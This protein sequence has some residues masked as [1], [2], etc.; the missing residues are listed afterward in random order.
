M[1]RKISKGRLIFNIFNYVFFAF[2]CFV[3]V[4]PLWH[5][6]C[7]SFSDAS[8]VMA[9]TG[10]VWRIHKFNLS[11]YRLVFEN[12]DIWSGYLNT[13]IYVAVTTVLGML[14]TVM[15]AYTCAK[16]DA[17]FSNF[18]MFLASFTMLFNGGMIA[19]YIVNT[20]ILN[21]YDSRLAIIL[22][23]CVNAFYLIL[24]R[25]A[26]Q[27]VPDSLVESAK[28]DGAN[29]FIILFKI[30]LPLI[31]ATLATVIMYY[32]IMQ[33]NSWFSASI[34][35]RS[36]ELFPLQLILK[37][38]LINASSSM[39]SAQTSSGASILNKQLLKYC[40]IIVSTAPI[41]F[42]YPFVSKYFQSGVMIGA[43]KG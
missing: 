24:I 34:Y 31:K 30:I 26:I 36:R 4:I 2:I 7:A 27:T 38:L 29:D 40:T 3:C 21:L 10:I 22:P 37:E 9:N 32:I 41:L 17:L 25:T 6:F 19:S 42:V 8:W 5:V 28:L 20:D 16:K 23:A 35:L 14:L 33:W 43:V 12:S 39:E 13:I 11:G 15:M 18:I 1:K